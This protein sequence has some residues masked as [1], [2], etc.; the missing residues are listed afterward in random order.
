MPPLNTL[1][2]IVHTSNQPKRTVTIVVCAILL[3]AVPL[4]IYFFNF[5]GSL[6]PTHNDWSSFGSYVSGVYG[7]LAFFV[8]AY[9][10]NITRRQ[11]QIQNEDNVFFKLYE[12]MQIRITNNS[13][14]VG[15]ATHTAHKALKALA[16][17]FHKELTT[18]AIMIARLLLCKSPEKVSKVHFAKIF[19]ALRGLRGIDSL[20]EEMDNFIADINIHSDF[21]ARWEQLKFHIGSQGE[22][23]ERLKDAL[24]ATGSV[25]FY[26]IPF[27]DRRHHYMAATQRLTNDNGEFLDGYIKNIC[28]ILEFSAKSVNRPIYLAFLKA[29]LTKYELVILFYIVAGRVGELGNMRYLRDLGIMDGL[30]TLGCQSLMIDVPSNDDLISEIENV[31]SDQI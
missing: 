20:T 21:N 24:R 22:E 26:K 13:T 15:D 3:S 9:T 7:T 10:T 17:Q 6:S 11:F 5:H 28:F 29:Q 19:E 30:L 14:E 2:P 16:T 27:S 8:L 31:F 1:Q 18:E 4:A 25:N 23:S 12:S